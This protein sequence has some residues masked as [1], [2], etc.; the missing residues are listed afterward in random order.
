MGYYRRMPDR[1]ARLCGTDYFDDRPN[2]WG[3]RWPVK[4]ELAGPTFSANAAAADEARPGARQALE[5]IH[6]RRDI[7]PINNMRVVR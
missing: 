2:R 1:W 6:R 5:V 7:H 3:N 4:M